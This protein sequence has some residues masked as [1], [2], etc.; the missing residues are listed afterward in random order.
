MSAGITSGLAECWR[1]HCARPS[2]CYR[3]RASRA[4]SSVH[5]LAAAVL[6]LGAS[7]ANQAIAAPPLRHFEP[8][9]LFEIQSA[10]DPQISPDATAVAYTRVAFDRATDKA[11]RS[12]WTV[13]T[14]SG[15]EA[16]I[17]T[18]GLPASNARWSPDGTRIAFTATRGGGAPQLYI[19][20]RDTRSIKQLT[21]L[22]EAVKDVVWSPDGRAIAFSMAAPAAPIAVPSPLVAPGGATWAPSLRVTEQLTFRED[23]SGDAAHGPAQL[24]VVDV[25][26]GSVRQLTSGEA[27]VSGSFAWTPDSTSIIYSALRPTTDGMQARNSDLFRVRVA[28][29][30]SKRLTARIGPDDSPSVSLDGRRIAYVGFDERLRSYDNRTL[31]VADIEGADP[32][33]LNV[34]RDRS[35]ENP[36]WSFDGRSLYALT[37]DHGEARIVRI[38][39]DRVDVIAPLVAGHSIDV[40]YTH[41]GTFTVA[42]DGTIAYT[43][44]SFN[45][46]PDI[47]LVRAGK[48]RQLTDLNREFLSA[49]AA[50]SLVKLPVK[51]SYDGRPIDAWLVRPPDFQASKRYPLILEIHGG[52]FGSYGPLWSTRYQLYASAGYA[53]LFANP[54]GST[55]Y[56]AE[57]ANLIHHH[58]PGEDYD[59]LMSAVDA[60]VA[61]GT[62]DPNNL[63]VTGGSGGGLLT[64]WIVGKTN[65]F[66]AAIAR[67][68]VINWV[69][70]ALSTDLPLGQ[71]YQWF[72]APP[73]DDFATYWTRSPLSLVGN[74]TTPTMLITGTEDFRTPP[75]EALQF[76]RALRL[77]GVPTR[78][79]EV[80]GASH[81]SLGSRPSQFAAEFAESVA[82]FRRHQ[83]AENP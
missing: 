68:P 53:V 78:L 15:K 81:D 49:R 17:P 11:T 4:P 64:A 46:P 36:V 13:E 55:S 77:R 16:P 59:D 41:G 52:P 45:R 35:V 22:P 10:E 25:A 28:D 27:A 51:S 31:Y 63:Y 14:E 72:G 73:W 24:F 70:E 33:P 9:D 50:P 26:G 60:A 58:F 32:K 67:K 38:T 66:R 75:T 80:P 19:V 37:A 62:V 43:L 5:M 47:A 18:G 7:T 79:I 76:F 65:R 6:W 61:T 23:G 83:S 40:P 74:V 54:R 12:I 71:V 30:V 20:I 82:W 56:G 8:A 57:F 3:A 42:R 48:I 44:G 2:A 69:S 21:D 39:G 1:A 34:P 29:A